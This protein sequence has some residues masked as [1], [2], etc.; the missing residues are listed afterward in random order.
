MRQKNELSLK[1][2]SRS[3]S[4]RRI[5]RLRLLTRHVQLA[6]ELCTRGALEEIG[7]EAVTIR[8]FGAT[9]LALETIE[10][11]GDELLHIV[12]HTCVVAAEMEGFGC[13]ILGRHAT[14][15]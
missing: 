4:R 6:L 12:L 11:L 7:D 9:Q 14:L 13:Q 8:A 1:R 3:R 5:K 10:E 2:I 15:L